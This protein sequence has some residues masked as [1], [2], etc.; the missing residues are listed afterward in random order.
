MEHPIVKQIVAWSVVIYIIGIISDLIRYGV[1]T[2]S[3]PW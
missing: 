1:I 3:A 2:E